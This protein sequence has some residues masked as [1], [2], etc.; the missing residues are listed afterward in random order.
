M[1]T[2]TVVGRVSLRLVRMFFEQT[3]SS[4]FR[5]LRPARCQKMV[6]ERWGNASKGCLR[7][8]GVIG[9]VIYRFLVAL[10][11]IGFQHSI[12][13][14]TPPVLRKLLSVQIQPTSAMIMS[15]FV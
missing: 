7:L 15:S 6:S 14:T 9:R 13:I 8:L 11:C 12:A 1:T 3:H 2:M 10:I 5:R 4:A